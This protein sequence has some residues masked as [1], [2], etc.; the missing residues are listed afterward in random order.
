[1]EM[2]GKGGGEGREFYPLDPLF[3]KICEANI[4]NN[5]L[6]CAYNLYVEFHCNQIITIE[7]CF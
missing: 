1:M 5:Y 4:A 3:I 7:C 6:L 2:L